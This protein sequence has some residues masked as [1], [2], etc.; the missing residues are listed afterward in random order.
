MP[1]FN[2]GAEA[3]EFI[4]DPLAPHHVEHGEATAL[5]ETHV[6]DAERFGVREIVL[7]T[8]RRRRNSPVAAAPEQVAVA[9][10]ERQRP[11]A[12]GRIPFRDRAVEDEA[13]SGRS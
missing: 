13:R 5:C 12:V 7:A 9:P 2:A 11:R 3:A 8:R 10:E 6:L 4:V 1:A